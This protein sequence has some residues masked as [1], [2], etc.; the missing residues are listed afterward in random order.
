[1]RFDTQHLDALLTNAT[2]PTPSQARLRPRGHGH[3]RGRSQI[4]STSAFSSIITIE[5]EA[6][7]PLQDENILLPAMP[8]F[9]VG[10]DTLSPHGTITRT[11]HSSV[12]IVQEENEEMNEIFRKYWALMAEADETVSASQVV[13]PDTL[14]SMYVRCFPLY[15]GTWCLFPSVYSFR[16]SS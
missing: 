16:T 10:F 6:Q 2:Q 15:P 8:S 12:Y 9:G 14:F 13:W 7:G 3:R 11:E 4:S 1:M 5:E